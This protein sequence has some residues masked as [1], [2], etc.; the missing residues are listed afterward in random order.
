MAYRNV[1]WI[2][3]LVLLIS[4]LST[5]GPALLGNEHFSGLII[6][7]IRQDQSYHHFADERALLGV[8]NAGDTLSNLGFNVVGI[9]GLVFLWRERRG[10]KHFETPR[11]MRAYWVFFAALVLT[12]I[13][14]SY[15]HLAPDDARLV[16][17]RLPLAIAFVA[18]LAAVITELV[19]RETGVRLL[20]P[21]IALGIGSVAYWAVIDDLWP[22]LVVQFG[23]MAELLL[24]RTLF[25]SRYTNRGMLFVILAVYAV[26]K[27][28]E[29]HD[30]DIYEIGQWVSGHTLKH[31]A[32][33]FSSYL[34]LLSLK[35]RS[36]RLPADQLT[37]KLRIPRKLGSENNSR[38]Y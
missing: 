20:V 17:D 6:Q 26:A 32:A 29:I 30:R 18:F 25:A 1:W 21:F 12:G 35:R 33:A 24:L 15:Y 3:S 11:E 22:Y 2:C 38:V 7:P 8:R 37:R 23:S 34:I 9:L 28:L 31:L 27:V 5:L 14:S 13:G 36:V 19:D 4:S 10:S 16:W